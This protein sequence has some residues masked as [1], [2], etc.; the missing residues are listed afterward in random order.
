[1]DATTNLGKW[2]RWYSL[3]GADPEPYGDSPTYAMAAEHVAG[4]AT[5]E[6]WGCGKGWMRHHIRPDRYL[7]VDGSASPFADVIADLVTYRSTCDAIIL[8]HVL[9]HEPR[10]A[11][12]VTNAVAS[13]SAAIAIILF[14][15]LSSVTEQIAWND[16]PGVPDIAFRPDDITALLD[17]WRCTVDTFDSPR[18]QYGTETF[19]G[20]E[21]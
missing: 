10:W 6:D 15:P 11:D 20:A 2:D 16:E 5:V 12:I 17:G 13:A 1:M 21:R 4:C 8:R 9:E 14:T 18:T 3:L 7:G 19:I